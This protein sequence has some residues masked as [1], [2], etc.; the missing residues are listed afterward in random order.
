[1]VLPQEDK[2]GKE[3][4]AVEAG[5]GSCGAGNSGIWDPGSTGCVAQEGTLRLQLGTSPWLL[6]LVASWR[7]GSVE[8]QQRG[9][10]STRP[11]LG[12]CEEG[13]GPLAWV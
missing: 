11:R 7:R 4:Q 6:G 8:G 10:S 9:L 12:G 3:A 13:R 5:F 1:M 2:L